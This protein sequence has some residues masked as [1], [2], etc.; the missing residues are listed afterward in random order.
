MK[1]IKMKDYFPVEYT[2]EIE[3]YFAGADMI[4]SRAGANSIFEILSLGKP[5]L[6]I[7]LPK[8]ES[9]GD[10]IDNAKYFEEKG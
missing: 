7:P 6:L 3:N 8:S 10:Q 1:D 2:G 4:V 9:R 5:A